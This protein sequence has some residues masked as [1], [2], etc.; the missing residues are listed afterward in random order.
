[1]NENT[2]KPTN[3]EYIYI[4]II[5]DNRLDAI[6]THS[7]RFVIIKEKPDYGHLAKKKNNTMQSMWM[8]FLTFQKNNQYIFILE[9]IVRCDAIQESLRI[10]RIKIVWVF[11]CI[12]Y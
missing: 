1:M 7:K 2:V 4:Y 3:I 12:L 8:F 11:F 10:E 9:Y 6:H 5:F